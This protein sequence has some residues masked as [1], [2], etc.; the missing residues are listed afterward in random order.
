MSK[1]NPD[2]VGD[3]LKQVLSDTWK[4]PTCGACHETAKRMNELGVAG[5]REIVDEL[6]EQL[7]QNAKAMKW[8]SLAAAAAKFMDVIGHASAGNA[9]YRKI[10]LDVCDYVEANGEA[11]GYRGEERGHAPWS[12]TIRRYVCTHESVEYGFCIAMARNAADSAQAPFDGVAVCSECPHNTN[13]REPLT[14]Q[15]ETTR[16]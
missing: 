11:C 13:R 14:W 6:A 3:V 4:I 12:K 1:V 2:R 5:C 15:L 9:M 7:H 16:Q 10:I 8:S